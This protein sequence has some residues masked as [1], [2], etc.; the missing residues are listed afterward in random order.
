MHWLFNSL[1]GDYPFI[2]DQTV[3]CLLTLFP[4]HAGVMEFSLGS[5]CDN[6]HHSEDFAVYL[7]HD[8]SMLRII[9]AFTESAPQLILMLAIILRQS[10]FD[11]VTG[12]K[13]KKQNTVRDD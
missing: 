13:K 12:T 6:D 1:N 8:L 11:P 3:K 7:T 9:E 10:L 2:P 5:L 4:R